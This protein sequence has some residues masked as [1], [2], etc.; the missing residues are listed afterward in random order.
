MIDTLDDIYSIP[1]YTGQIKII[2]YIEFFVSSAHSKNYISIFTL[3]IIYMRFPET[4]CKA[5]IN[6]HWKPMF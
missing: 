3:V 4:K 6:F 5:N 2:Y 1:L